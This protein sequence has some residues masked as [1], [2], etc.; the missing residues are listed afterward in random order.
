MEEKREEGREDDSDDD[1]NDD[2]YSASDI[3]CNRSH[4][5]I[6]DNNSDGLFSLSPF[7]IQ[8]ERMQSAIQ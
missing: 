5:C 1:R 2:S 8:Q 6:S 4:D 3:H 7:T